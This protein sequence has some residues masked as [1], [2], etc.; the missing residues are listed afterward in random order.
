LG[1]DATAGL[2]PDANSGP[3][4]DSNVGVDSDA[5][6]AGVLYPGMSGDVRSIPV[7]CGSL[8][9]AT[10]S[11]LVLTR[12]DE[13]LLPAAE[14]LAMIDNST[15]LARFFATPQPSAITF[16]SDTK[17][18]V[19]NLADNLSEQWLI[20][21]NVE[22]V[23]G[24]QVTYLVQSSDGGAEAGSPNASSSIDSSVRMT[25]SRI[26]C[27]A[28]DTVEVAVLVGSDQARIFAFELQD[29]RIYG[30]FF[31]G[32][33]INE[34]KQVTESSCSYGEAL[35]P[36]DAGVTSSCTTTVSAVFDP[37]AT[38]VI[39]AEVDVADAGPVHAVLAVA[40]PVS[41]GWS[42]P[43]GGS[44][45]VVSFAS[46]PETVG[47]AVDPNAE[48]LT[49]SL[50]L[51]GATVMTTVAAFVEAFFNGRSLVASANPDDPVTLSAAGLAGALTYTAGTDQV[52]FVGMNLGGQ[53]VTATHG[54][55]TLMEVD[56]GAG[57]GVSTGVT[58]AVA[59]G[60]NLALE[61]SSPLLAIHYDLAS[62]AGEI[63]NLP[64]YAQGD[65]LSI[66]F[67]GQSPSVATL[68]PVESSS[69]PPQL[70]IFGSGPRSLL[71]VQTGQLDLTSSFAPAE[72]V[73][74]T[75]TQCLAQSS[76]QSDTSDGLVGLSSGA[77]Q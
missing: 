7:P 52:Q 67:G 8:D 40:E 36:A 9:P 10:A 3:N 48:T 11:Q 27:A 21:A 4:S 61:S 2:N 1:S 26:D 69:S 73:H 22:S 31:L 51:G 43:D 59:T 34:G 15:T 76:D 54:A 25:V 49:G 38:G 16:A 24:G 63:V 20:A 41:I 55:D 37:A 35:G 33:M 68:L 70:A 13:V 18:A 30:R 29:D 46:S 60:I 77:C 6:F 19:N 17:T 50:G 71:E 74:V 45:Q 64:S 14:A 53:P 66:S 75:A 32:D 62:I 5:G 39:A 23:D 56:F 57:A 28:G 65:V 42:A 58:A 47:V 12:I 72:D 44:H